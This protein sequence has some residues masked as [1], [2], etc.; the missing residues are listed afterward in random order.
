MRPA[1]HHYTVLSQICQHI[2]AHLV[3]KLSRDFGVDQQARTFS[4]WSHVVAMLHVHLAHSLSLNDVADTL[5]NHSGVLTTIRRATPPS[6]NGLSH[7]NRVRDPDMAQ[8]LFWAVLSHIQSQHPDFGRGH[9]YSGL[10]KR[11]KRAIHAIDSTTIQLVANCIDWAK[12]RRRKAAAKCHMQLNLQT[13]L[14]Q[15]AIVK[16]ASTHDSTEAYQLCSNL[17]SGEIAVFDKAYVDFPHLADLNERGV[18]WV[19]RAK[20]NMNYR[21]VKQ[22]TPPKGDILRDVLIELKTPKSYQAY[23]QKLRLITANVEINGITKTMT[24]ITNNFL[25]A[26]SSISDLYKCRWGIEVFFKQIK[27]TLQLSDFLGHS[28]N[29]ILWQVWMAL[30]AYVLIRFIGHL[31]QWKGT[32]RRLF[33]LLRGVLF[34]RLDA[35]SVMLLCGT[36]RGSPRMIGSP[37]QAYLPGFALL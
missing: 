3:S 15:F 12:H 21:I 17:K 29:A 26:P 28:R 13:F 31:G 23:P 30:L 16:E 6:R 33:T 18:F 25:W 8:A 37:Q 10:P 1:K 14:P 36:A 19:T 20:D 27:Q 5:R 11:F 35:M 7:A 34:S 9:K 22:H 2:P 24:F 4:P 32:F